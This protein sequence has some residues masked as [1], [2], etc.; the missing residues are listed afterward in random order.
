MVDVI[1]VGAGL[2]GMLTARELQQRGAKVLLLERGK[3]GGEST[4]AGGGILSP[5]YPWRY[6]DAVNVLAHYGHQNYPALAESLLTESGID[7]EYTRSGMFILD[8]NETDAARAWALRWQMQLETLKMQALHEREPA[9]NPGINSA[10][11]LPNIAQLRNPR[12][13]KSVQ[14]SLQRRGITCLEDT[15]VSGLEIKSGRVQGVR[16]QNSLYHANKVLIAGG[17]WSASLIKQIA[18]APQIQP[19]KGQM[20]LFRGEPGV[21]KTMVLSQGRYLI[22]RRDGRILAGSTL[23]YTDFDKSITDTAQQDLRSAA[24]TLLP[25]L[26]ELPVEHHWA[27]LRPGSHQGVPYICEHP[28]IN[29]LYINSGHFRNGVILGA[30]SARLMAEL[31]SGEAP[32]IDPA[33]YNFDAIH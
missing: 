4:W 24:I 13:S 33:F 14:G 8:Q 25:Q 22:P 21:L 17:A 9:L 6:G 10:M 23:E 28:E 7:P 27:G 29:G 15:E 26:A 32:T 18:T 3:A 1:V 16:A 5:L 12:L 11:W 20:I 2:I 19:V 30:G 31:M